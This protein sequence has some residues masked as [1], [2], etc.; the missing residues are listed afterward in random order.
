MKLSVLMPVY[1]E[2]EW[3]EK[4]IQLVLKQ[5]VTGIDEIELIIVDDGSTDGSTEIIRMLQQEFPV[6][7]LSFFH[8]R[9]LGKGAAIRTAISQMTGEVCI[10]QDSD[11]EYDPANYPLALNPLINKSADC[12][13]GSRFLNHPRSGQALSLWH[14]LGNRFITVLS[15]AFTRLQLT[16]V[17]TGCKAFRSDLFKSIPIRSKGFEF[18]VEVTSKIARRKT[19]IQEVWIR[20]QGRSYHKGK[21]NYWVD[22][23]K[24]VWAIVRF[25]FAND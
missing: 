3:L 23:L 21:K 15:N 12:V 1:N 22:G 19:K 7:I 9:N 14:Y 8:P 18:E 13:Y 11:L 17:E 16:D 10:I 6:R 24:A 25:H 4:I 2:R 20:Y 5:S